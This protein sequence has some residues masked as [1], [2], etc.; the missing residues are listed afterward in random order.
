VKKQHSKLAHKIEGQFVARR[1][2]ML[3]SPAMRVLS[4]TA[5]RIL[6]RIEIEHASHGGKDNGKLPVTF[7]DLKKFGIPNT[8][9]IARGIREVCALGLVELTRVGYGGNGEFRRPNLFRLTYLSANGKRPTDEWRKFRT[10]EEAKQVVQKLRKSDTDSYPGPDTDSYPKTGRGFLPEAPH[11]PD[12]DSYPL[13]RYSSH[14]LHSH[15]HRGDT[16]DHRHPRERR[17]RRTGRVAAFFYRTNHKGAHH[18]ES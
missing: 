1:I 13:S 10:T 11:S 17:A 5:R 9:D 18:D 15:P 8:Q 3:R 16:P 4:L 2:E 6:D 12:T 7:A 14:L